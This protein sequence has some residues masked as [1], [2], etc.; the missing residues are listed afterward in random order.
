MIKLYVD[1]G[2][3]ENE[4]L[5]QFQADILDTEIKRPENKESTSLGAALFAGIAVGYYAL[6]TLREHEY[7]D[8]VFIPSM[9]EVD[10]KRMY[11][12]WKQAIQRVKTSD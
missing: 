10:R 1:G 5:M 6:N 4:F 7:I 11:Q 2:A 3:V 9:P 12:G 8:R